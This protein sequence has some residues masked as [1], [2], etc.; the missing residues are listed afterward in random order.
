MLDFKKAIKSKNGV[1]L[2]SIILGLG[3]AGLFKMSCDSRSCLIYKGPDFQEKRQIKVN[4]K[5]YNVSEEMINCEENTNKEK[6][7]V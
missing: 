3:F 5:C 2:F 1:L 7:F 4:E 6:I